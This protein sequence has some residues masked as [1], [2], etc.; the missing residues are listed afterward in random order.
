MAM[1]TP[2]PLIVIDEPGVLDDNTFVDAGDS[3]WVATERRPR[4]DVRPRRRHRVVQRRRDVPR[5]R[6]PAGAGLD[7]CRG[8]GQRLRLRRPA[9]HRRR[10]RHRHRV[11]AVRRRRDARTGARAH[12]CARHA[13]ITD[14]ERPP[15]NIT[16]VIDTSGSMDIRERL[17]LV[18]SSLA[19]LVR[20][21]RSDDTISI[22]TYGD[23]PR[24][25]SSRRR[26]RSGRAS[27]T[28]S[29]RCS[30]SGS[31]NMEAGLL[32]GYE[33]AR[34]SYDPDA[35]NVVVLGLRRR[36]QPG[37]DRPRRCSPTRS[38]RRVTR[39]STSS[40]SATAWAT[41]TTT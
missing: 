2:P 15:A 23:R 33:A 13:E 3:L 18:Q 6:L 10:P 7:P 14:D 12:R 21:L 25:C 22:V 38:P 5:Q 24:R 27:S 35:L 9:R 40:P 32:L 4:V 39:A 28:P 8:V 16:F 26:S 29:T 1:E 11:G 20:S 37:C 31:T 41:T 34:R 30:P 17:G 19:L 36:R